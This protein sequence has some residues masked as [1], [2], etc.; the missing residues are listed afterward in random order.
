MT[1]ERKWT[2]DNA[3]SS[4]E[5]SI[6]HMMISNVKGKFD[7]YEGEITGDGDDIGS[8]KAHVSIEVKSINTGNNDRD[9]HLRSDEIF[10]SVK[11]PIIEFR[12]KKIELS[13]DE[14]DITGDLTIRG[15]TKEI[16]LSGEYG[17][18]IKDPF[19]ND[20]FGLSVS[21]SIKRS[22]FGL[23][24]NMVLEGGG[25]MLGEKVTLL[26]QLEAFSPSN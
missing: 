1:A 3:H 6:K 22:D 15:I 13:G 20:R 4:M 11:Y 12:S 21:T 23:K 24:W 2:I 25:L 14:L 19:G 7:S 10:A 16:T 18:K 5:F 26:I 9:N 8:M 17:G